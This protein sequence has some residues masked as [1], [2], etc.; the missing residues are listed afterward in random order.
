MSN[1]ICPHCGTA[2]IENERGEYVTGC[3]HFP[4]ETKDGNM[5]CKHCGKH[6]DRY[7]RI[8]GMG[9]TFHA[10]CALELNPELGE[11]LEDDEGV[12]V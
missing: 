3:E 4:I 7:V 9:Y 12:L 2:I 1:F 6:I 11:S 8:D 5:T 10:S